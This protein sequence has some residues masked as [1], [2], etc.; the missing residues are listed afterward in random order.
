M[1]DFMKSAIGFEA[2]MDDDF[3]GKIASTLG[4]IERNASGVASCALTRCAE[5][6][7]WMI[8]CLWCDQQAMHAHFLSGQLQDLIGLLVSKSRKI[9]FECDTQ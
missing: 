3:E 6:N 5:T 9:V 4:L 2:N 8:E 7:T 1:S